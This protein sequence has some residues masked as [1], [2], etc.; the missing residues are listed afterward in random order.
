MINNSIKLF[1][2]ILCIILKKKINNNNNNIKTLP[3]IGL[4]EKK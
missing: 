3:N 2:I 4:N 1:T